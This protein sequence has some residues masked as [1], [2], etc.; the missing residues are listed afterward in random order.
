M[1]D[2]KNI[3][4][5][6]ASLTGSVAMAAFLLWAFAQA[7]TLGLYRWGYRTQVLALV[8][9]GIAPL[10]LFGIRL[11]SSGGRAGRI[12]GVLCVAS[13]ALS[14]AAAIGLAAFVFSLAYGPDVA[15]PR[16]TLVDP[17]V[18]IA[19][20]T[21][22]GAQPAL[23]VALSSDPHYGRAASNA[24]A[25][26]A[27]LRLSQ[28]E[29]DEGRLDAFILLGDTVEMGM[30]AD[31]W[32][33]ARSGLHR[34]APSLPFLALLGNHDALIGGAARWRSAFAGSPRRR[35]I[36]KGG[37]TASSWHT[38][39]GP[40]HFIALD[41]LWGPEGFGFREKAWLKRQLASI[42]SDHFIV[43]L[44]HCFFYSSGYVDGET[45]RAWYDHADMLRSVAPLIAGKA[46]LVVSGHNH[47]MEWIEADG[48]AWA[49]VGAM[50]GKPDPEPTYRS[51]GSVWF[52]RE[53][54]GRL[55][56]ELVPEG[57]ACEFQDQEGKALFRTV[58]SK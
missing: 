12:V 19:T 17:D 47:Y 24:E 58:L 27:I 36:P 28:R 33:E 37:L 50:G 40:V 15:A 48:S 4:I 46:D 23:R 45:G 25:R 20:R 5:A 8:A 55:V 1:L 52:A 14:L 49:V 3:I 22:P 21:P 2:R 56:V 39:A 9:V 13:S 41:L 18:G 54:Y 10:V 26:S 34:D 6:F 38:V 42:P 31:D 30:E 32:E 35:G 11:A 57:L 51:P 29:Y 16:P 44:S 7:G 53:V 43:I